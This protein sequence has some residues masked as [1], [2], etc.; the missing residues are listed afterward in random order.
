MLLGFLARDAENL[1]DTPPGHTVAERGCDRFEELRASHCGLLPAGGGRGRGELA[2]E[3]RGR[4]PFGPR[5]VE[6]L[7][8][9]RHRVPVAARLCAADEFSRSAWHAAHRRYFTPARRTIWRLYMED[10][11][12]VL[13]D[14]HRINGQATTTPCRWPRFAPQRVARS[15]GAQ[16]GTMGARRQRRRLPTNFPDSLLP[17]VLY[18]IGMTID[19]ASPSST[20]SL[21]DVR[22]NLSEVIDEVAR[23]GGEVVITKHGK[24]VAVLLAYDEYE[25]LIET[26]N[27]L[28]DDETMAAIAESEADFAAGNFSRIDQI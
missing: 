13:I 4:D 5:P 20:S 7:A 12:I 6:L 15:P 28:S 24:P 22:G 17:E 27:V 1:A 3:L 2:V 14:P 26:V 16:R 9:V 19:A 11:V 18:T 23:T 10:I 21:T 8:P 25:S